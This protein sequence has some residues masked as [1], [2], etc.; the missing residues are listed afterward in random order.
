MIR[1]WTHQLVLRVAMSAQWS[2]PVNRNGPGEPPGLTRPRHCLDCQIEPTIPDLE[3]AQLSQIRVDIAGLKKYP[4]RSKKDGPTLFI[5][6][7]ALVLAEAAENGARVPVA[8]L[9][10]GYLARLHEQGAGRLDHTALIRLL[11]DA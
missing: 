5:R 11:G 1:P 2:T 4:D 8:T 3:G 6:F 10:E 7:V 9:V